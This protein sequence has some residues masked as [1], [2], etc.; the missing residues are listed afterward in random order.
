MT[1]SKSST[2]KKTRR[3]GY[4]YPALQNSQN[5][6][7]RQEE[8]SDVNEYFNTLPD[9]I[10]ETTLNDGTVVKMNVKDY[11][12]QFMSEY[13]NAA[14]VAKDDTEALHNTEELRKACRDRNNQRNAC[15]YTREKAQN[16]LKF[17]EKHEDLEN[18][19]VDVFSKPV[20]E[21]RKKQKKK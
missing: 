2:K 20:R 16:K 18:M 14:G 7:S 5:L 1:D 13:N 4:K 9:D 8:I 10:V 6:K 12:N 3:D 17:V 21:K 19:P 15:I 11:M